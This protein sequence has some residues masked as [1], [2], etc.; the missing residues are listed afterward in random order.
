M[1]IYVHY[2]YDHYHTKKKPNH[3]LLQ[4]KEQ[5]FTNHLASFQDRKRKMSNNT[6][7][8]KQMDDWFQVLTDDS[9]GLRKQVFDAE[10]SNNSLTSQI[11]TQGK[12][13]GSLRSS[14]TVSPGELASEI[15][16]FITKI[17]QLMSA[18]YSSLSSDVSFDAFKASVF[19]EYVDGRGKK[20]KTESSVKRAIIQDIL[21]SNNTTFNKIN[22]P[23]TGD[24]AMDTSLKKLAALAVA[25]PEVGSSVMGMK[26]K[27]GSGKTEKK[28]K[29]ETEDQALQIIA[30]KV[31]GLFNNI[32]GIGG[33]IAWAEAEK[34][35]EKQLEEALRKLNLVIERQGVKVTTVTA[36]QDRV[37]KDGDK[38]GVSKSDVN[39]TV[40]TAGVKINYGVTVKNYKIN[41]GQK[42]ISI[43]LSDK[44]NFYTTLNKMFSSPN[45]KEYL[46]NLAAGL[47]TS[48]QD[49]RGGKGHP[50]LN[51]LFR[52]AIDTVGYI[53]FLDALA[54]TAANNQDNI[55]YM[56][57]NGKIITIEEILKSVKEGS[58]SVSTA[59]KLSSKSPQLNRSVFE[60]INRNNWVVRKGSLDKGVKTRRTYKFRDS[61]AGKNRSEKVVGEI[62]SIL[63]NYKMNITLNMVTSLLNK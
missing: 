50:E 20:S 33:E 61:S 37:K 62:E 2:W 34:A 47:A 7:S 41:K 10:M 32:V 27:T 59:V 8:A 30:G 29:I 15:E 38:K 42:K 5:I 49:G 24:S 23:T 60:K 36:G 28:G 51:D 21:T 9:S 26:Y 3:Q 14:A 48:P 12:T 44:T 11:I 46:Y 40:T 1:S 53:H 16:N 13:A 63:Q 31:S 43:K 56:V 57:L 45:E 17:D 19:Q 4:S 54:G 35:G 18:A 22:L 6:L 58:S 55:L 52:K 25:L 39:V